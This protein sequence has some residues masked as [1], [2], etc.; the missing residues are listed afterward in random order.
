MNHLL[1]RGIV[2]AATAIAVSVLAIGSLANGAGRPATS[3]LGAAAPAAATTVGSNS[4][5]STDT[6]PAAETGTTAD[7]TTGDP[8]L[9]A[10]LAAAAQSSAAPGRAG[11][12]PLRR[13]GAWRRLV[14]G[15]VVVDAPALGGL[16]TI[17]LDHGTI[18]AV[19]A[20]SLTIAEKG[21]GSVVVGLGS[22]THVRRDGAKATVADLHAADEIVVMSKVEA[23]GTT[24]YL[25][26]VPR[27]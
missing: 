7:L 9:D 18:T 27:A 3:P 6:S 20:T 2:L 11:A 12:G 13:L 19:S 25:V 26:V 23:N 22:E 4:A 21:G 10:L 14:H 16:T 24:A 15:T 17:Q 5:G 8:Q 1:R